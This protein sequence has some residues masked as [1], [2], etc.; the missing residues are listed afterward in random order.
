VLDA[1]SS[2]WCCRGD[3]DAV[4]GD[5][6]S[7]EVGQPVF[8]FDRF[9]FGTYAQFTSMPAG[10]VLAPKPTTLTYVQ[11]GSVVRPGV[12]RCG[13]GRCRRVRG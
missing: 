7:F 1:G 4:G 13:R 9:G 6:S 10:G 8:G 11:A 3:V 12:A 2:G 5:V